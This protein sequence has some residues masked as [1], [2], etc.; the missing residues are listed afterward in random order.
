MYDLLIARA[1]HA[2]GLIHWI[3]G[4]AF[5][6]T[7]VLPSAR[8]ASTAEE[9]PAIF[10][11]FE[12]RFAPQVRISILLVGI[13][14]IYMMSELRAWSRLLSLSFWW[15]DLM[16]AVWLVFAIMVYILEPLGIDRRFDELAMRNKDRAFAVMTSL[17]ALALLVATIA[18]AAGVLGAHGGL[19]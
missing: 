8:R 9:A 11:A 10:K 16:I 6:T 4:V 3:G 5:V 19:P 18:I 14:G 12:S 15:L 7:I 13:T 1:I 17:H 2:L